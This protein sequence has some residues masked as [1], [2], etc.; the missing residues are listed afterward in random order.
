MCCRDTRT[1]HVGRVRELS[2]RVRDNRRPDRQKHH[3][4][5]ARENGRNDYHA[6]SSC[7]SAGLRYI[8]ILPVK[9]APPFS[10][11]EGGAVCFYGQIFSQTKNRIDSGFLFIN[12]EKEQRSDEKKRS[13]VSFGHKKAPGKGGHHLAPFHPST[14]PGFSGS[15]ASAP[16]LHKVCA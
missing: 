11:R 3:R 8:V 1:T 12:K 10:Y 2:V 5:N 9:L 4:G 13:F 7:H 15:E 6:V 16:K 14:H